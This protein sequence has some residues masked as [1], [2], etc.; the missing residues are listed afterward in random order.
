MAKTTIHTS[1]TRT[2]TTHAPVTPTGAGCPTTSR[3]GQAQ[4]KQVVALSRAMERIE[5][6]RPPRCKLVSSTGEEAV[7]PHSV[8]NL[9]Y[10]LVGAMASGEAVRVI[11]VAQVLTTQQ[12]ADILHVSR[13]YLVRLLEEER[14]PCT[15]TGAHRRLRAAD[16]L[17]FK[18]ERDAS[19][20]AGLRE[21]SQ[22]TQDFGG[23]DV[24]FDT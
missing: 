11:S 19:R 16:V 18:L 21:L 20:R 14:I 13:Q 17:A 24:E 10:R 8:F 9:L 3:A 15:K 2:Q 4:R 1:A 6:R 12:A 5:G 7:V 22:M 23:Y